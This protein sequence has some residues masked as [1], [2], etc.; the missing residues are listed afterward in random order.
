MLCSLCTTESLK[1]IWFVMVSFPLDLSGVF[2][3]RDVPSLSGK[4]VI[5]DE[6]LFFSFFPLFLSLF[7]LYNKSM[8]KNP[9]KPELFFFELLCC[10][11]L[12]CQLQ[13]IDLIVRTSL[14]FSSL[15]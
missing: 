6:N 5:S 4:N 11:S 1:N 15:H 13:Y 3:A 10:N 9:W 2:S 7:S 8:C 14:G 12:S